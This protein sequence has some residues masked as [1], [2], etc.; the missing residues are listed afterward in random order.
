MSRKAWPRLYACLDDQGFLRIEGKALTKM[1][2]ATGRDGGD[3]YLETGMLTPPLDAIPPSPLDHVRP[4]MSN[5]ISPEQTPRQSTCEAHP[6]TPPSPYIGA[7]SPSRSRSKSIG[8]FRRRDSV[9][10]RAS[11]RAST[12]GRQRG[13][14]VNGRLLGKQKTMTPHLLYRVTGVEDAVCTSTTGSSSLCLRISVV[15]RIEPVLLR[16]RLKAKMEVWR[17]ALAAS[18]A[19]SE[20]SL[21]VE[22]TLVS[23]RQRAEELERM[24]STMTKLERDKMEED[25]AEKEAFGKVKEELEEQVREAVRLRDEMEMQL[26]E[27]VKVRDEVVKE[28]ERLQVEQ[29]DAKMAMRRMFTFDEVQER[30]EEACADKEKELLER[31]DQVQVD[32][33]A[34]EDLEQKLCAE[35]LAHRALKRQ[36]EIHKIEAEPAVGEYKTLLLRHEELWKKHT[37]LQSAYQIL[38]ASHDKEAMAHK[39]LAKVLRENAIL[40]GLYADE[41]VWT[42]EFQRVMGLGGRL[43]LAMRRG[44]GKGRRGGGWEGEGGGG[45]DTGRGLEEAKWGESWRMRH[46]R[47]GLEDAKWRERREVEDAKWRERREVEDATRRETRVVEDVT[48]AMV[49]GGV[50]GRDEDDKHALRESVDSSFNDG[51]LDMDDTDAALMY[52]DDPTVTDIR[53]GVSFDDNIWL[54]KYPTKNLFPEPGLQADGPRSAP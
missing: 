40:D 39:R 18:I 9:S 45:C 54:P 37:S 52:Y 23:D 24:Q 21:M 27:A 43:F 12:D 48:R 42:E 10:Q 6:T 41:V 13:R 7:R 11:S 28:N 32:E 8:L 51:S 22:E 33:K 14:S 53:G 25:K 29:R 15:G 50:S 4:S 5:G 1:L 30:I 47:E 17:S 3:A 38:L 34:A 35:T 2:Q 49:P 31:A 46:G 44:E 36:V 16:H 20:L 26:R 19:G